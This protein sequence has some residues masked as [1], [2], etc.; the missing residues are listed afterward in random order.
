MDRFGVDAEAV[1]R[2]LEDMR[3]E[4]GITFEA[5]LRYAKRQKK[6]DYAEVFDLIDKDRDGRIDRA[7]LKAFLKS[8]GGTY[9]LV[10]TM[11]LDV[12][13]DDVCDDETGGEGAE[14]DDALDRGRWHGDRASLRGR[15]F[16]RLDGGR[17]H[18]PRDL[19][20]GHAPGVARLPRLPRLP[21]LAGVARLAVLPELL[22]VAGQAAR[23]GR[24]AGRRSL[25][26]RGPA[27]TV[28]LRRG[29]AAHGS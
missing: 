29:A 12:D 13:Y 15:G 26:H 20:E 5:Y 17:Q 10:T 8:F 23:G 3:A 16:A 19:H 14:A 22:R 6:S 24:G 25:G 28:Q 4:R 21:E 2:M 1:R 18:V 7:D 9:A 27:A 11:A